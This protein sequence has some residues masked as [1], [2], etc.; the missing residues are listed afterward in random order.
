M[1]SD[2]VSHFLRVDPISREFDQ[3]YWFSS[4]KPDFTRGTRSDFI[5]QN[6]FLITLVVGIQNLTRIQ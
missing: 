5:S 4:F 2:R 3:F 1:K 6:V